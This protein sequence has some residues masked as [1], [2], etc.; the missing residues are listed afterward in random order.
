MR[1]FPATLAGLLALTAL[2]ASALAEPP[3]PAGSSDILVTAHPGDRKSPWKRA[4]SDHVIVTSDGSEGELKRVSRNLEL[5][6]HLLS[7]L[8]RPAGGP[9]DTVKLQVTLFGSPAALR[10]MDLRNARMQEGPYLPGFSASTYYDPREDGE[11]LA[12]ARSDQ[13]VNLNTARAFNQDCDAYYANG[14][15][16]FC[17]NTS[18]APTIPWHDPFITTWEEAL[19][20]R[21]A[22]HFLLTYD[23]QAYPRWYL[24]GIGALF[25]TIQVGRDGSINYGEPPAQFRQV[26][27]SFGDLNVAD[28]VTGRY[29]EAAPGKATWTPVHA[30]FLTHY[31]LFADLKPERR[32]QFQRYM[33]AIRQ[34]APMAEAAKAFGNLGWLQSDLTRRLDAD[35]DYAHAE[36]PPAAVEEPLITALSPAAAALI[37]ARLELGVP[38]AASPAAPVESEWL[39]QARAAA[40]ARKDRDTLLFAAEA[41]CRSHHSDACLSDA[42]QVL[43]ASPDDADALAWKGVAL[44]DLAIAGPAATRADALSVARQTIAR[45]IR[46]GGDAPL[47]LLADFRSYTEASEP[48]PEA[49]MLGMAQVIRRVPAAP[50]PRLYLAEELVRQGKGDLARKL[51]SPVLYGPYDSPEHAAAASLFASTANAPHPGP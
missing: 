1:A 31:F 14:G 2:S 29:L 33:A 17:T 7:R 26:F 16:D 12:V 35:V 46:A 42:E 15:A 40:D 4:E 34:G 13:Q 18:R 44:T 30:W 5:L 49:A 24:D 20:A 39:A 47:P 43:A 51:L 6:Y 25:S 21:F 37:E 36:P 41:E 19:Y 8:Y 11:V 38:I 23:P 32:A 22:Q 28:I 45:A 3:R 9:D 27:K 50:A 48:V 10:A